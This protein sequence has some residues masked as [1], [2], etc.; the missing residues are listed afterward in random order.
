M[1]VVVVGVGPW[2][3]GPMSRLHAEYGG[4]TLSVAVTTPEVSFAG[5][6]YEAALEAMPENKLLHGEPT[7]GARPLVEAVDETVVGVVLCVDLSV[8]NRH[9]NRMR[10][11]VARFVG[12]FTDRLA[13]EHPEV[14]L[15]AV[16]L[17]PDRRASPARY[18]EEFHVAVSE[19]LSERADAVLRVGVERIAE[20]PQQYD[21]GTDAHQ[22]LAD[23]LGGLYAWAGHDSE[24]FDRVGAVAG[25]GGVALGVAEADIDHERELLVRRVPVVA[26]D[27]GVVLRRAAERTS[28]PV[29][30]DANGRGLA[31]F[32]GPEPVLEDV[33]SAVTG[34]GVDFPVETEASDGPAGARAVV[35][36]PTASVETHLDRVLEPADTLGDGTLHRA[37]YLPGH[38]P[39]ELEPG[40]DLSGTVL[41]GADA[42]GIS[43][44]GIDLSNA[45]LSRAD[46]S[47]A[48]LSKADL[49]RA[50]LSRAA[51]AEATLAESTLSGADAR[52]VDGSG[53]DLVE[54]DL[55]GTDLSRATL[56][57]AD[58]LEAELAGATL[59]GAD[60]TD[61]TLAGATLIG[62]D[63]SEVNCREADLAG[64]DLTEATFA[65]AELPWVN[66]SDA[67][68]AETNLADATVAGGDLSGADLSG[69]DLS[70]ASLGSADL[71]EADL[72]GATLS[73]ASLAGADLTGATLDDANLS[74][75]TL[76]EADCSGVT[77]DGVDLSEADCSAAD[78]SEVIC[79]DA[80]LSCA[81]FSR[82]NLS[83]ADLSGADLTGVALAS[84]DT[85]DAIVPG[86]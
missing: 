35:A 21:L 72:S 57:E 17:L 47:G 66:L 44:P 80:D 8:E 4:P 63:C 12:S 34:A 14:G 60:L 83:G 62:A 43:A 84:A 26:G 76:A 10:D 64:A 82:A 79:A 59:D 6:G 1:K 40:G 42:A 37:I 58:L 7:L 20:D 36:L 39:A 51:L 16:P 32:T 27:P 30:A 33:P 49:S 9:G 68:L 22:W 24:R 78:L 48:T 81:T 11:D 65:G 31:V 75:A 53:A 45:D 67:T 73:G 54:G 77:L 38:A 61:A 41:A 28:A 85:T 13:E 86:E 50:D 55:S 56:A 46:L 69:A 70:G 19:R 25:D 52:R 71:S 74:G 3:V 23:A 18:D 15:H 2:C 5:E 29:E